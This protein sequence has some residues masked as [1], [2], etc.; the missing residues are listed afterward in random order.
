MDESGFRHWLAKEGY[1]PKLISDNISRLKLVV[2]E[3]GVDI[4]HLYEEGEANGMLGMFGRKGAM[5]KARFPATRLP[6]GE[7]RL[8]AYKLALTKYLDYLQSSR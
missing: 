8:S 4:N 1:S 2:A 3:L 5:I 6:V 7:Y